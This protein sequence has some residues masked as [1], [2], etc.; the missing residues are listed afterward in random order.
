MALPQ[1]LN[2]LDVQRRAAASRSFRSKLASSNGISFQMGDEIVF[3]L[4][5]SVQNSFYDMNSMYVEY[6]VTNNDG[7]SVAFDGG[8]GA[9]SMWSRVSMSSAGATI[10]NITG[11]ANLANCLFDSQVGTNYSRNVAH[12]MLGTS[13]EGKSYVGASIANGTSRKVCLPLIALAPCNSTPPR[14][15]PAMSRDRVQLRIT[16]SDAATAFYHTVT[17]LTDADIA[18]TDV[19]LVFYTVELQPQVMQQIAQMTGNRFEIMCADYIHASSS[20]AKGST[21]HTATL[22]FSSGS[23]EAVTVSHRCSDNISNVI[24]H[25]FT[26]SSANLSQYQLAVNNNL[27]PTRPLLVD[28]VSKAEAMAELQLSKHAL[29][30]FNEPANFNSNGTALVDY[31]NVSDASGAVPGSFLTA[32][33]LESFAGSDKVYAGINT[34]AATTQLQLEYNNTSNNA[35]GVST[36][37]VPENQTIDVYGLRTVKLVLDMSALGTF[38]IFV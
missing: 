36:T 28:N 9:Y 1:S 37:G 20:V 26:R 15:F 13:L 10:S 5:G 14:F 23:L 27:Y 33:E 11:F 3:D 30:N 22:G 31:Y 32:I 4:P 24:R 25:S 21:A 19:N 18:I 34:V 35:V 8:A 2:Y 12:N 17:G 38:E 7:A 16:L 29:K 6:T